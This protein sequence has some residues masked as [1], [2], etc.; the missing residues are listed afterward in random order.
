MSYLLLDKGVWNYALIDWVEGPSGKIFSPRSCVRGLSAKRSVR[1]DWE[2]H[3]FRPARPN[4]VDKHFITWPYCAFPFF[5]L[6]INIWCKWRFCKSYYVKNLECLKCTRK[7][8][9]NVA[10]KMYPNEISWVDANK[11]YSEY[12]ESSCIKTLK[13]IN[14][15]ELLHPR[16]PKHEA[17]KIDLW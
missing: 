16:L 5:F 14:F 15:V 11:L 2:P 4:S 6:H 7:G 8:H 17:T 10:G 1:H 13:L 3:I 9:G 12:A